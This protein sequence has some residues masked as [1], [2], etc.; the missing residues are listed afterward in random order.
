M[1]S[2]FTIVGSQGSRE[3]SF[4]LELR[5]GEATVIGGQFTLQASD[6]DIEGTVDGWMLTYR[7][8]M[9]ERDRLIEEAKKVRWTQ[10]GHTLGPDACAYCRQVHDGA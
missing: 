3:G 7:I 5:H 2:R 1:S 6:E 9:D 10:Q 8:R 4:T